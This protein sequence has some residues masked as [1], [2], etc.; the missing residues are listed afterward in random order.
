MA[1]TTYIPDKLPLEK[2]NYEKIFSLTGRANAELARYDGLLQVI[3]THRYCFRLLPCKRLYCL[4]ELKVLR[5]LL[6][7]SWSVRPD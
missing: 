5:Q 4:Q 1:I 3:P 2:L 7:R 6:M